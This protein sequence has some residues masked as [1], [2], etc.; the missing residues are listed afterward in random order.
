[1][2]VGRPG[3][4]A[5]EWEVVNSSQKLLI[6]PRSS[7][8]SWELGN[9]L[10]DPPAFHLIIGW[11]FQ[12]LLPSVVGSWWKDASWIEGLGQSQRYFQCFAKGV[13]GTPSPSCPCWVIARV[14]L[15]CLLNGLFFTIHILKVPPFFTQVLRR[16]ELNV[17]FF[18]LRRGLNWIKFV[19]HCCSSV[20]LFQQ[21]DLLIYWHLVVATA[22]ARLKT[23]PRT[24]MERE[25]W[26]CHCKY[27]CWKPDSGS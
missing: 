20:W 4:N 27:T 9:S 13:L 8:F 14:Y 2:Q 15:Y 25:F 26:I 17:C 1:M 7:L 16:A 12:M 23:A 6:I 3:K 22:A 21:M 24:S 19:S 11:G 18:L 10:F 5:N